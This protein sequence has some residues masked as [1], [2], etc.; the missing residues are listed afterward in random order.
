MD[1]LSAYSYEVET[2]R[3]NNYSGLPVQWTNSDHRKTLV[4]GCGHSTQKR[5]PIYCLQQSTDIDLKFHKSLFTIKSTSP[6]INP[7]I[8]LP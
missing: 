2:E 4:D 8:D 3:V 7:V 5:N 1:A 6:D